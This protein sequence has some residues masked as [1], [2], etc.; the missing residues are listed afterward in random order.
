MIFYIITSFVVAITCI[1]LAAFVYTKDKKNPT[2][3]F[4]SLFATAIFVW[5]F[6]YVIWLLQDN[7]V[8]ALFWSRMLNL[9]ATFIP[10]TYLH[11]VFVFLKKITKPG[12]K[13]Y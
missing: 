13:R 9:G 2:N 6:S 12:Q 4:F 3:R 5:S 1:F 10:I 7:P 11:W 8:S